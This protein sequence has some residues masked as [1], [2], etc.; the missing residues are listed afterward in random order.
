[1]SEIQRF[2][3]VQEYNDFVGAETLH[4][5]V[6]VVD[7]S[8][9][10]EIRHGRKN[11]GIYAVF[12]KDLSCGTL[13]YGRSRYDYQEGTMVFVAPGQVAGVDDNGVTLNPKGWALVFHPDLLYGTPLARRMKDYSFFRYDSNEALHMSERERQTILTCLH[14]IRAELD[15]AIDRHSK[16]II[17]ANIEVLLNHCVRFYDRQFI[18]RE[19]ANR[20]LLAD[21]ET[22]LTA[23]FASDTPLA[24]GLPT[25]QYCASQLHLSANYFGDLIKKETGKSAQEYIQFAIIDRAKALIAEEK[26]SI[27]EI[28]YSLGFK[29]PQHLSRMFKNVAGCTPQQYRH[30]SIS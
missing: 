3:T 8:T 15:H 2:D 11:Y 19:R 24:E 5:L 17:T 25:V 10:D 28:A 16:Q 20:N 4:P 9:L 23:Y 29:Y 27:S 14:E 21:F 26:L 30:Q 12:L 13:L 7:F 22:L 18:T 6:S 1:M